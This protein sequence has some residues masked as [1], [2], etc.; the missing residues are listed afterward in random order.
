MLLFFLPMDFVRSSRVQKFKSSRVQ[1]FKSSTVQEFNSSRVQ[2]VQQFKSSRVQQFKSSR[3][4]MVQGFKSSIVQEVQEVQWFKGSRVQKFKSSRSSMVQWFKS[5]VF[6]VM[7]LNFRLS[8]YYP[9]NHTISLTVL[10]KKYTQ[11]QPAVGFGADFLF[12]PGK[13]P[14]NLFEFFRWTVPAVHKCH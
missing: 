6:F 13:I 12:Q 7:N 2:E 14:S 3:S 1:K 5:L 4:S 9:C 11:L 8:I 10:F